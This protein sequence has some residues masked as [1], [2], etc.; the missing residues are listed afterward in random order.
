MMYW[1]DAGKL[2][3]GGRD[4]PDDPM[5]QD[6]AFSGANAHDL[7]LGGDHYLYWFGDGVLYRVYSY[8]LFGGSA[9]TRDVVAAEDGFGL[10][11]LPVTGASFGTD[12][13]LHWIAPGGGGFCRGNGL[14]NVLTGIVQN[15]LMD[16]EGGIDTVSYAGLSDSVTI[17]LSEGS[18]SRE[19]FGDTDTLEEIENALGGLGN[20]TLV[21]DDLN[22]TLD[23]NA[24]ADSMAGGYGNDTYVVNNASDKVFE[25]D[26]TV[27]SLVLP[28]DPGEGERPEV[29]LRPPGRSPGGAHNEKRSAAPAATSQPLPAARSSR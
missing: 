7:I 9:C 17:D 6:M 5:R 8:C 19:G 23:G 2:W 28:G 26:N 11:W 25:L 10:T 1:L 20:D 27:I 13:N 21:G 14:D 3:F 29:H 16:G 12:I 24:G 4:A 22:N 15:V 18:V